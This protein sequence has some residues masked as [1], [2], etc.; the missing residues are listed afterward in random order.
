MSKLSWYADRLH[1]MSPAEVGWRASRTVLGRFDAVTRRD[2]SG[3]AALDNDDWDRSLADF[4]IGARRPVLLDRARARDLAS[5]RPAATAALLDAA[6]DAAIPCVSYF[7]YPPVHL[8]RP[9]DWHHDPIADIRWPDAP[10]GKIDH[11][12]AAGDVKWI[13]ELNRLQHLPLLAEAWLMT[14]DTRFSTA[15][16]DQLDSWLAQ[17]PPGHG[18]AWRGAFEAGVRAISVAIAVQGLRD[19]PELSIGRYRAVV[20]MLTA[21]AQRCWSDRSL[22][23]SA[24]N[25]LIGEMAGLAIVALLFPDLPAAP[26]WE[27]RA[28]ATLIRHVERQVLPDGVGA[29]QAVGYQVFTAELVLLVTH[30]LELRDGHAP[31]Q[32]TAAVAREAHLLD[33]IMGESDPPP[34][35]GDDDEGFALR[36]GPEPTRSVR[37]HLTIVQSA[38][39]AADPGDS[40]TAAW[41]TRPPATTT[42]PRAGTS[43]IR[44]PSFHARDGGLVVLR[45]NSRR[46]TMD[47]GS[48]GFLSIAAH[49][50]ADAL[51]ITYSVDGTEFIGDPGPGSYYGDPQRRRVFRGTRTHATVTVDGVDQSVMGGPFLWTRHAHVQVHG[52][53]LAGGVID[54][55]HDGYQRLEAP[56]RHRRWL[57][58]T[59]DSADVLVVD[60]LTGSGAHDSGAHEAVVSWPL[61]PDIDV[62]RRQGNELVLRAS[63]GP[64]MRLATAATTDIRV[65]TVRGDD[66]NHL[67]WWSTRLETPT[68]SWLLGIRATGTLPLA[69]ATVLR[70]DDA[71]AEQLTPQVAVNDHQITVSWTSGSEILNVIIDITHAARLSSQAMSK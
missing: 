23:S 71:E 6:H 66:E 39:D 4:R 55:E 1:T 9:I 35:F 44:E 46:L 62:E 10:A 42:P 40:L 38:L 65:D 60:L 18:I 12:T 11:R 43:L 61:P 67:G 47:V 59:P 52:V 16:L 54:A 29:E 63:H 17:N 31:D 64:C 34:R 48:L 49:G 53:D 45:N 13:W 19:A 22:F 41:L 20:E 25:H 30:L 5:S 14:G 33:A 50:H 37:E 51:A 3:I 24:N 32:L 36:L 27:Q 56:V 68:P 69:V 15:A 8:T 2:R 28:V 70:S 58:A 21:S 57:R 26:D 7:G